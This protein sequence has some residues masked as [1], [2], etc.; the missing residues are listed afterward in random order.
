MNERSY[1]GTPYA[2]LFK[3]LTD[4]HDLDMIQKILEDHPRV[5][6]KVGLDLLCEAAKQSSPDILRWLAEN[7][8]DINHFDGHF[9]V[10]SWAILRGKHEN[11]KCLLELGA[12]PNLDCPLFSVA[13]S[14]KYTDDPIPLAKL[15]LDYGAD[16]NHLFVTNNDQV[17]DQTALDRAEELGVDELSAFLR[18]NGALRAGELSDTDAA[19]TEAVSTDGD[20][21]VVSRHL[22]KTYAPVDPSAYTQIVSP[23]QIAVRVLRDDEAG[24]AMLFTEGLS[25][26][27]LNV[28]NGKEGF[29]FAELL[30]YVPLSMIDKNYTGLDP[31]KTWPVQW[32]FKIANYTVESGDW[33]GDSVTS[34]A[35][36]QLQPLGPGTRFTAW[37]LALSTNDDHRIPFGSK[38]EIRMYQLFP[39]Y[40]EEYQLFKMEGFGALYERLE[41]VGLPEYVDVDR[42]NLVT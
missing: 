6:K 41:S 23:T 10:L 36:E 8:W 38:G 34:F 18:S 42:E 25:Q 11:A 9:S 4:L 27:E 40:S 39:L 28:P 32:M 17:P 2:N 19:S 16:I 5:K 12:D 26:H 31:E 1:T 33:L 37:M 24:L 30:L 13:G 35:D 7:G 22:A 15:L 3:A 21:E 29:R 14:K 20:K